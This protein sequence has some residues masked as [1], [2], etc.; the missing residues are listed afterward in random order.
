MCEVWTMGEILVEIMR[1]KPELP[2]YKIDEFQGPFPSGAP[3]IFID[4][5]SRL[6]HSPGII[7]G[8]GDDDF[9]KCIIERLGS[10]GV[11]CNHIL[12]SNNLP[13]A[14]A[15]VAYFR[16]GSRKFIYHINNTAA[17]VAESPDLNEI[18]NPKFIHIMG[19]SLMLNTDF[20]KE[21]IKTVEKF[22]S[23]GAEVSF[24]PNIR[25]ELLHG[26]SINS[27]VD[28]IIERCSVLLPGIEELKLIAEENSI[29]KAVEKLFENSKLKIIA[30]KKGKD[31]CTV[32][33]RDDKFDLGVFK[34]NPIDPTGAGD[35]FDAGF[36]C[37]LLEN[38]SYIESAK[39]A[40]AAASLNTAALGP[41]EGNININTI[42]TMIKREDILV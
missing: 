18:I 34:I 5:V 20:Y 9:G 40:T 1:P 16:D 2:F 15:F 31:G 30:L 19:C 11:N 36:L 39:I 14:I 13:T 7:G 29:D 12:K 38:K 33:S 27:I 42:R 10:D 6:G 23:K 22:V 25:P 41:M 37:G 24:D 3:A 8:V 26:R 32:Y 17:T 35:C 21:I 4:T 28:V